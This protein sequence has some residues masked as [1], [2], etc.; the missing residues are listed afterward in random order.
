MSKS[1]IVNASL[2]NRPHSGIARY[3]KNIYLNWPKTADLAQPVFFNGKSTFNELPIFSDSKS[4]AKTNLI[5]FAKKIIP[6]AYHVKYQLQSRNLKRCSSKIEPLFY[7]EPN[8]ISLN[9]SLP[10]FITIHDLAFQ[11]YPDTLPKDRLNWLSSKIHNSI[12]L[13]EKIF[14]VSN[15]IKTELINSFQI[16][17]NKIIVTYNGIEDSFSPNHLDKNNLNKILNHLNL[18]FKSFFLF[19]GNIEPRKNLDFLLNIVQKLKPSQRSNFPLVVIGSPYLFPDYAKSLFIKFEDL[20][21]IYLPKID[22]N[23]LKYLY[24]SSLALLFPS[25]YEGFG[26]PI[27]EAKALGTHVIASK[28]PVFEELFNTQ[29]DLCDLNSTNDWQ[30]KIEELIDANTETSKSVS[31]QSLQH[32]FSWKNSARIMSKAFSDF[33][34]K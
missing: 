27:L 14:T 28:I 29:V 15:T 8:F 32:Q 21:I 17:P 31:F 12:Q 16:E 23:T 30:R 18:S 9:T 10:K 24:F 13:S 25:L 26:L 7:H 6:N 34:E 22:D 11:N 1:F 4:N 2:L 3:L 20:N 5:S 19:V 33:L